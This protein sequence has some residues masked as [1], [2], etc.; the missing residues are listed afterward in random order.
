MS[1]AKGAVANV[2]SG[3]AQINTPKPRKSSTNNTR[4]PNSSAKKI[5]GKQ[6]ATVN[7]PATAKREKQKKKRERKDK[8]QSRKAKEKN[9]GGASAEETAPLV[10]SGR[11]WKLSP[12]LGGRFLLLDPVF[13]R[14]EKY[15]FLAHTTSL[16]IFSTKTSLLVRTIPLPT[17]APGEN[18]VSFTL[19]PASENNVYI[20]TSASRLFLWDW[21]SGTLQNAWKLGLSSLSTLSVC[22]DEKDEIN[23]Y[24]I[25]KATKASTLWRIS[26]QP[27][28]DD[29]VEK[30][31]IFETSC[32]ISSL[33]VLAAGTIVVAIAGNK[34]FIANK[35]AQPQTGEKARWGLVREY[36]MRLGLTCMDTHLPNVESTKAGKKHKKEAGRNLGD[37]VVGDEAGALHIFHDVLR[38]KEGAVLEPVIRRLHWHRESVRTVKWALDGN[39]LISGGQETV[40]VLWQIETSHKQFLPHLGSTI[41]SI[42]VSPRN[43]SYAVTL[44]DNSIMVLST[45][46]LK[47]KTNIAG[48]QSRVVPFSSAKNLTIPCVLH[49]TSANQLLVATP[50]EQTSLK[51][52]APY[53]Q[54]FDT[55]S[56]R[57]V[58]RQALTRTNATIL[59]QGPGKDSILEPDISNLAISPDGTWLATIDVWTRP[60]RDT[61]F[62]NESP[63]SVNTTDDDT[64]REV[65]LKFFNWSEK[66]R[67]WVLVTRVDSPHPS[68]SGFGAAN[69]TDLVALPKGHGFVTCGADG[70]VL[71]WR[72]KMRTRAGVQV[73][74]EDGGMVSWGC[75]KI[76]K[77]SKGR[78]ELELAALTLEGAEE[79]QEPR[80]WWGKVAISEDASLIAVAAPALGSIEDSAVVL[81][82]PE[83]AVVRQSLS[84][85]HLGRVNG[86]AVVE[87][88][89][90]I[91]GT[92]KLVVWNIVDGRVEWESTFNAFDIVKSA[93]AQALLAVDVHNQ[94]FAIAFRGAVYKSRVFVFSTK[95]SVPIHVEEVSAL[96]VA[97]KAAG[98]GKGYLILDSQA[99]IQYLSPVLA[100]H[101]T[102]VAASEG[103]FSL[104]DE[105]EEVTGAYSGLLMAVQDE[106]KEKKEEDEGEGVVE[107][108]V[109]RE[110]LEEV[111]AETP[112]WGMGSVEA[113]FDRV[114]GLFA[115][116]PLG[117]EEE[118]EEEEEKEENDME[119][120]E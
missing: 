94:T 23:V 3:N 64:A 11:N 120:E 9:D 22:P 109:P 117:E 2:D 83:E 51:V 34:L 107:R 115:K 56:D 18:I 108:V 106:E 95:T 75:R 92:N 36:P 58:S 19:S 6:L 13:A 73:R 16:K 52:S 85:L 15:L 42:V 41:E 55:F 77:F 98:A 119:M 84:G 5:V 30:T 71:V 14:N 99:R 102:V 113:A 24:A 112:S 46:E 39:Y 116:R 93:A 86:L 28:E 26:L 54:T 25:E 70:S 114:L 32:L 62:P 65:F 91:L 63:L 37:V 35:H 66:K 88:F 33:K 8:D 59:N 20:S 79:P 7:T 68:T 97:L 10:K 53:L 104:E 78:R 100:P 44:S 21:I 49:P 48:I 29:P 110:R 57:H 87:R 38:V 61:K 31:K 60:H 105:E 4:T 89:L 40:L 118:E 72:A 43:T 103:E 82:D 17:P 101:V 80:N 50:S 81:I 90:V 45:T 1:S 67:E 69:V 47:P 74:G 96:V 111:F 76:I 12:T 27:K